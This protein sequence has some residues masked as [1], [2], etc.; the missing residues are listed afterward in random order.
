MCCIK[1]NCVFLMRKKSDCWV[2]KET[3]HCPESKHPKQRELWK[4]E[5]SRVEWM[6]IS[7]RSDLWWKSLSFFE[8]E[9]QQDMS[10]MSFVS[11]WAEDEEIFTQWLEGDTTL[12][13]IVCV[14]D[15]N[16]SKTPMLEED[17]S[18]ILGCVARRYMIFQ[19]YRSA[20]STPSREILKK[21]DEH[22]KAGIVTI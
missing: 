9:G 1:L 15:N 17:R 20:I 13:S 2:G 4:R 21:E 7:V 6:K 3:F 14:W 19:E 22:D 8:G 11:F 10:E 18:D 16:A 12:R 5:S